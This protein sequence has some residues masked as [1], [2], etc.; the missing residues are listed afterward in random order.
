VGAAT[1]EQLG[2]TSVFLG[3]GIGRNRR[4]DAIDELIDS[5]SIILIGRLARKGEWGRPPYPPFSM[6]KAL[7]L[8]QGYGL[9][10][11]GLE[12]APSDQVSFRRFCGLPLDGGAPDETTL[13]RFR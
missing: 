12:V 8:Q 5:S 13:C 10:D 3:E 7:L 1:S 11:S 6:I 2:F 4:L 9:S